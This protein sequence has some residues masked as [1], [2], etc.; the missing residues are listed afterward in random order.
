[1][2]KAGLYGL[3]LAVV[4]TACV[5]KSKF[6][7]Q[8]D[9]VTIH[10]PKA[11]TGNPKA[12]RLQVISDKIIHV[13]S[14]PA[15]SFSTAKSLITLP[16][17]KGS[18]D[19]K[20]IEEK[21]QLILTTKAVK[22]K[23]SL[24]TGEIVF[25]DTTGQVILQEK[26]GGGKTF[27]AIRV[28]NED[29]YALRQVFESPAD[30]AFYGLGQHQEGQMNYKGKD[31][32]LFQYNTKVAVPFVV[33]NKNYGLLWD[34]YSLTRFGD[35]REYNSI[36]KLKLYNKDG[37]EGGLSAEYVS[38]NDPSK[39]LIAREDTVINYESLTDQKRFPKDF[40]LADGL[41][42]WTGSV[43]SNEEGVHKFLLYYA[44]YIKVWLND[45]LV[46]DHWRQA[47][48]PGTVGFELAM[49]KGKK[50]PIKIEWFPDGGESYLSLKWQHAPAEDQNRLSLFSEAGDQIDYYFIAGKNLDDVISG[51]RSITGK[52]EIFPKWALGF[53]QSRE[54]YKTQKEILDIAAEFRKRK[55]PLDNIVLDWSYWK[56]DQ[57]GSQEFDTERFPDAA[58]MIKKL[59]DQH[60]HFMISA[61]PKFY[62][63][64]ENYKAFDAKGWLYKQ[65]ITNRQRDW[66]GKG[67]VSTF[68]DPYNAEARDAF[69][70]LLHK[71]LHS[72][73]V[74]AWW[75]DATEPDILSNASISERK[76]LMNPTALGSSTKY[77]NAFPLMNEK[78]IYEGLKKADP[79]KRVFIL[80]RSA[81]AG[82]QRY[83]AATWS[84]DIG[85]N[86]Q[87]FKTQLSAGLNFS[88]SGIPYWTTDIGG[89]S[90]ERKF[91][92]AKG[93][94]LEEWRE[95]M[96]RWFQFGAFSPLFRA[97][98]QYPFRE[99]FNVA[100]DNHPAYKTMLY[101]DKLRYRLMP[102]IYSLSG[103]VYFDDYTIMR[104]L[105]M[106]FGADKN[107]L[108]IGTSFM[109]GPSLLVAP[110]TQHKARTWDVYLP[111]STGWYDFHT[112]SYFEG[113]QT[114]KADAPLENMPLFV[115]AGAIIPAGPELQYTSEKKA[116]P[117]TL[118]VYTGANGSFDL[119]EDEG[120]NND[121]QKGQYA[122]IPFSYEEASQTLK[123]GERKGT[124][125]GMLENRTIEIVWI[126]KEQPAGISL[127][128]K[129]Q[130]VVKY[131]GKEV[132]VKK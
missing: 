83:A 9:G 80:T 45:K 122:V 26:Q 11:E 87:D 79:D 88:L 30:E 74:D 10:F 18:S 97:H 108:N 8:A 39:I 17:L 116:D 123:I 75:M 92:N 44:G 32:S 73:G 90:V 110:V 19:W 62:E 118:Y 60:L 111:A 105:V 34:N 96:T 42:N 20:L 64:T 29:M 86:W 65:N 128:A 14:S 57:W 85:A 67:Y 127:S 33:S 91:E 35:A 130:Q 28:D 117:L 82:S 52:A 63:G 132:S 103:K 2:R 48:N 125:A 89:F 25:S 70:E 109:Y 93:E 71:N 102:Y 99:M 131:E 72:K 106:D 61:W 84:G 23:V 112:G 13:I 104:A 51:Y 38:K 47:W 76:K 41:V 7:K 114:I 27:R 68:Y 21:D 66:I 121:Y 36:S 119:Y 77:F 24:L 6:E 129:P 31:V 126:S 94:E 54:R 120:L 56:V 58:A 55:I 3:V 81:F 16:D 100:P 5:Q 15:D 95:R 124:Y 107:V 22:A 37:K 101:Y 98:G 40:P 46:S 4:A 50:Y 12:I 115:K 59:H 49:E 113:G 1:M 53:W 69:W 78:G 43:E